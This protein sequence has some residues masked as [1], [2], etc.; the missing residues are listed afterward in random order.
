MQMLHSRGRHATVLA[1]GAA[2]VALAFAAPGALQARAAAQRPQTIDAG[3][4]VVVRTTQS[5]DERNA[6]GRVFRGVVND[7]IRDQR[8]RVAIPRGASVD[9]LVRDAGRH[10]LYLD[11]DSITTGGQSY[12]VDATGRV[13]S[14]GERVDSR[15]G[16]NA[17]TAQRVGGGAVIGTIIGA[18]VG[19]GKGA[20][21]GAATGAAVGAS[22]EI[23]VHGERVHVPSQSIVTF[24]LE[25]PLRLG[26][27]GHR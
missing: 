10:E 5:I 24:R 25:E 22:T 18:V 4:R 16:A 8:N 11:L 6:N 7:D 1:A 20:A 26:W 9:L 17:E 12:G 15:V 23:E 13:V 21:I 2:A 3:T 27:R 19:G 14:G